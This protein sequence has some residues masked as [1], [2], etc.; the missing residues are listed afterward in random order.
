MQEASQIKEN[1]VGQSSYKKKEDHYSGDKKK[2]DN[3]GGR[4]E[5]GMKVAGMQ[6]VCQGRKGG[7][8][9]WEAM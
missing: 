5:G 9:W 3:V 2:G 8:G 1:K 4:K 6:G 7:V